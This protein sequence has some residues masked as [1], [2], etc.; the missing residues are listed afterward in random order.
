MLFNNGPNIVTFQMTTGDEQFY[1]IRIYV[2]PDCSNGLD[3][4]RRAW[5]ACPQGCKPIVL[6]D[7]NINFGYPWDEWEEIIVDLLDEINLIDSSCRFRLQTL[8]RASTRAHWT[9]SQKRRG[10]R[11]YTQ[12][13]YIMA[14]AGDMSQFKGVG[15]RS[16]RFLHLDH[17]AVVVNIWE[18]RKGRL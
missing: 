11:H 1:V 13:D 2:P 15:F 12:P 7:L 3:D 6:G 9:W 10:T 18:G 4:L 8:Q 17:C 5:D 16:P 14:R